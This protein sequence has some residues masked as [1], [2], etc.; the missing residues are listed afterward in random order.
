[1]KIAIKKNEP[2]VELNDLL[3]LIFSLSHNR[4]KIAER[5]IKHIVN[6]GYLEANDWMKIVIDDVKDAF[7]DLGSELETIYNNMK[8]NGASNYIIQKHLREV[9]Q[10]FA[11]EHNI[12]NPFNVSSNA[13]IRAIKRLKQLGLIYRQHGRYYLSEQF[14]RRLQEIVN[15]WSGYLQK[16][17][18]NMYKRQ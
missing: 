5:I 1:M 10:E 14:I 6:N 2:I 12:P 17:E 16:A 15:L 18:K 8:N 11:N 4:K 3:D 13:Y 7:P 9:S